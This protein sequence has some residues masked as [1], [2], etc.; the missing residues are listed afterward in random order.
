MPRLLAYEPKHVS[1]LTGVP[2][3]TLMAWADDGLYVPQTVLVDNR[4][5]QWHVY[6]FDELVE[7]HAL[8]WL[9]SRCHVAT[10][11][12]RLVS[13]AIRDPSAARWS[14]L[15][16]GPAGVRI[17]SSAPDRQVVVAESASSRRETEE[18][19]AR[20]DLVQEAE[21]LSAR[22]LERTPD[23]IGRIEPLGGEPGRRPVLAGTRI[24]TV[25]VWEF[26]EAGYTTAGIIEQYPRLTEDDVASAIAFEQDTRAPRRA[27]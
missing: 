22:L 26:H 27:S 8:W 15:C 21:R 7:I 13:A 23:Q 20:D 11:T 4:G 3:G 1:R 19:V 6:S 16:V 5:G 24:P 9:Y 12:L 17:E 25:A 10:E 18:C 2:A 14:Q